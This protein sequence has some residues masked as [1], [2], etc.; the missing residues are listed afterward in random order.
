MVCVGTTMIGLERDFFS[1]STD[2]PVI[3]TIHHWAN[4]TLS[5]Q[6]TDWDTPAQGISAPD[7]IQGHILQ[8]VHELINQILK[9]SMSLLLK[10]ILIWS[11]HNFAAELSWHVQI[12][13]MI[14]L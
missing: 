4:V 11:S 6:I 9:K 5:G 10:R 2:L 7:K 8:S 3:T 12:C 13:G 1:V 14:G